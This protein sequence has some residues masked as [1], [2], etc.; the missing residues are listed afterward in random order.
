MT[1]QVKFAPKQAVR[2]EG[3]NQAPF[4][5]RIVKDDAGRHEIFSLRYLAYQE[6]IDPSPI[7]EFRDAFDDFATT[8]QI[9]AYD[10]DRLVGAMRLCFSRPWDSLAALPCA[11][12]YPALNAIKRSGGASL[13]EVSRF[14]IDPGI[15]NTSYR[16]TLYASLVRAGLMAAQA[17]D[18]SMI[19]VA[20]RPDFVRF[21][22]YMLGFELIGAPAVYPP[23]DFKISLLGGTLA[24]AQMRQRL[25][26]K[27]FRITE[28]EIA[29]MRRALAPILARVKAA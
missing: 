26:N 11:A 14:S 17:A 5:M 28:D 3:P 1:D 7:C 15:D 27:F 29:S 22:R 9:G 4:D 16:T 20:T 8:V 25:Q 18:V 10:G 23:G 21:Y 13:M 24:Q 2:F 12:Y 19:L 6:F